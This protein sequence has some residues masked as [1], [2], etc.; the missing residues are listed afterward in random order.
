MNDR[1]QEEQVLS[2]VWFVEEVAMAEAEFGTE[3]QP[4]R[5]FAPGQTEHPAND[6]ARWSPATLISVVAPR[7]SQN[8]G[9]AEEKVSSLEGAAVQLRTAAMR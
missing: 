9:A 3:E 7:Q 5:P 6:Q 4:G 1:F 8:L 2:F